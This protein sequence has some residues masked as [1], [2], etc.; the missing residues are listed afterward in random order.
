ME[1]DRRAA[2]ALGTEVEHRLEV[3]GS[4]GDLELSYLGTGSTT[5]TALPLLPITV[6]F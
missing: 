5:S 1:G 6:V 3:M 4:A 2:R